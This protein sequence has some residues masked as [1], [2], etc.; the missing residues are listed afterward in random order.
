MPF[1]CKVFL[2]VV[3]RGAAD[4]ANIT[5]KTL[6]PL[7]SLHLQKMQI[8]LFSGRIH[9]AHLLCIGLSLK[10]LFKGGLALRLQKL[11]QI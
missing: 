5:E 4:L 10:M 1:A 2:H 8:E 3:K 9:V 11:D 7:W 6:I